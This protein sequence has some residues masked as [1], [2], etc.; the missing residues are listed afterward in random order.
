MTT[1]K[2]DLAAEILALHSHLR[3]EHRLHQAR[4]EPYLNPDREDIEEPDPY[5]DGPHLD[6]AIEAAE[7]LGLAVDQLEHLIATN[8][9]PAYALAFTGP[10][11]QDGAG[12]SLSAACG[13][14]PTCTAARG[15]CADPHHE[16]S[17]CPPSS[18]PSRP[19]PGPPAYRPSS[20]SRHPGR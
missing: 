12:P 14:N 7:T 18:P 11:H 15:T 6:M 13:T 1:P 4:I 19:A 9:Q 3:E 5:C 17:W 8:L 2:P 10:D 16:Q 20:P